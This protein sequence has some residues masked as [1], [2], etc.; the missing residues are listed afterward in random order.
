MD[1]DD[2]PALP[3]ELDD[4]GYTFPRMPELIGNRRRLIGASERIAT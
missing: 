3:G 2:S 4:G 1:D